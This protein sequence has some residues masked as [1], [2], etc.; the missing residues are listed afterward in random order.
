MYVTQLYSAIA[1]SLQYGNGCTLRGACMSSVVFQ[2]CGRFR[3]GNNRRRDNARCDI[4]ARPIG[5]PNA[6]SQVASV[7][8]IVVPWVR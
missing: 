1:S 7:V 5:I 4:Y 2:W 8:E 6:P 3:H